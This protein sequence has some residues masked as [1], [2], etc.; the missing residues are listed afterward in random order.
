MEKND[1]EWKKSTLLSLEVNKHDSKKNI[2][3]YF[4]KY[5]RR[6]CD[7]MYEYEYVKVNNYVRNQAINF[8]CVVVYL[9]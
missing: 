4:E 8:V 1:N 6:W 5:W 2:F 3:L 9:S 7:Y